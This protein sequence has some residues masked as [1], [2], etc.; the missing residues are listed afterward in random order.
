MRPEVQ[1]WLPFVIHPQIGST[2]SAYEDRLVA[3][4]FGEFHLEHDGHVT[5]WPVPRIKGARL[6][7]CRCGKTGIQPADWEAAVRYIP[8]AVLVERDGVVT[9]HLP[10][11]LAGALARPTGS[12][13]DEVT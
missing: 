10:S 4:P 1:Q 9:M 5:I 13:E 12:G 8:G 11:V 6:V 7:D 3:W 2:C